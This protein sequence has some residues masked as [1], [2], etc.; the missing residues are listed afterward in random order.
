MKQPSEG[1]GVHP[2]VKWAWHEMRRQKM[3]QAKVANRAGITSATLR[4]WWRGKSAPS[5]RDIEAVAGALG[6]DI[7]IGHPVRRT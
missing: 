5:L 7:S 3:S 6:Y 4:N 1:M 2:I